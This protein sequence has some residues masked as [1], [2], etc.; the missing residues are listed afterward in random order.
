MMILLVGFL[1]SRGQIYVA[2]EIGK[3]ATNVSHGVGQMGRELSQT[4][5]QDRFEMRFS[6]SPGSWPKTIGPNKL[7]I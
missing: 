6:L 5:W 1:W 4:S 7:A 2:V 3:Q